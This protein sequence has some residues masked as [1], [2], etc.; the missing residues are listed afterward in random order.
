MDFHTVHGML[1]AAVR[2]YLCH[3]NVHF[4][5]D[6]F[7]GYSTV[8]DCISGIGCGKTRKL[9]FLRNVVIVKLSCL[10]LR[11][12]VFPSIPVFAP[13]IG[14]GQDKI[15]Y[16]ASVAVFRPFCILRLFRRN[17]GLLGAGSLSAARTAGSASLRNL[18]TDIQGLFHRSGI[19][20]L[21]VI[22]ISDQRN[23]N[24]CIFR[25]RANSICSVLGRVGSPVSGNLHIAASVFRRTSRI[26]GNGVSVCSHCIN[27]GSKIAVRM[28]VQCQFDL[29]AVF[30]L[31]AFCQVS[32][33]NRGIVCV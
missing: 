11:R 4:P 1:I 20:G 27:G 29:T 24:R 19:S 21:R 5:A 12:K 23:D 10:I 9:C 33:S 22:Q 15:F 2:P 28:R 8:C 6:I 17:H 26:R 3:R 14:R 31:Y 7:Y 18:R 13:S 25:H 16:R 32:C 30:H